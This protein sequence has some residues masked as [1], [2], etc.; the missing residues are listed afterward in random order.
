M[1]T[2]PLTDTEA[3]LDPGDAV[4]IHTDGVTDGQRDG[5]GYG[6]A[7][8]KT[9][10]ERHAGSALTLCDGILADALDFQ[11]DNPRDDIAIVA[12]VVCPG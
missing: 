9:A 7:R 3:V 5:I 10:I 1:D 11:R 4:V 8:L 6:E 12:I 2:P